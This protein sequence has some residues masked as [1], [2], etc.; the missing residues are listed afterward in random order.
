MIKGHSHA[1]II[2]Y[3]AYIELSLILDVLGTPMVSTSDSVRGSMRWSVVAD[4]MNDCD[5]D[6][7]FL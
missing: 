4:A 7:R 1:K 3:S 2:C 5:I 6:G